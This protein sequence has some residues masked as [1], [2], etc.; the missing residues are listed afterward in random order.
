M[1]AL[2]PM[3][4]ELSVL[5]R[6]DGSARVRH[7]GTSVLCAVYGPAEVKASKECCDRCAHVALSASLSWYARAPC[8]Q[9]NGRRSRPEGLVVSLKAKSWSL[10][11]AFWGDCQ[12][13]STSTS[14]TCINPKS[15]YTCTLSTK[16]SSYICPPPPL[17]SSQGDSG[18][19]CEA[20]RG[21]DESAGPSARV[22]RRQLL[23]G[24][25][26]ALPP[27]PHRPLCHAAGG[28]R[29]RIRRLHQW[30]PLSQCLTFDP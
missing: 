16:R 12:I 15:V 20:V 11:Q 25:R 30:M 22:P 9:L 18:G 4:S 5:Q 21:S 17:I 24:C 3:Q 8:S 10:E 23:R 29:R 14:S 1:V 26:K 28:E 19:D 6:A 7:G 13:V 27:P 2:R